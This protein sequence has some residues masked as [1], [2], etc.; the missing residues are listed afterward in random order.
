MTTG[1]TIN[2]HAGGRIERRVHP[3]LPPRPGGA[4]L[5][6][7]QANVCG[8]DVHVW[9]GGHPT[10]RDCVLGHEFVGRVLRLGEPPLYDLRGERLVEG[11]RIVCTYF[12]VCRR[13]AMCTR[14]LSNLCERSYDSW[15]RSSL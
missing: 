15:G 5:T 10:L 8:S 11:D 13:C 12:R 1:I 3:L 6:V 4:L 14:G 7:E 9:R 2:V